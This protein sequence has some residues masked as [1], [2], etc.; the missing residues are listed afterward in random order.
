MWTMEQQQSSINW[1]FLDMDNLR[2]HPELTESKSTQS[3]KPQVIPMHI[4]VWEAGEDRA[5]PSAVADTLGIP[6]FQLEDLLVN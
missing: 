4:Q 6:I 3:R 2:L 1:G 5:L